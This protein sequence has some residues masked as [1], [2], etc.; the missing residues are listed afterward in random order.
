MR[1]QYSM[2]RSLWARYKKTIIVVGVTLMALVTVV[3]GGVSYAVYQ[4]AVYAKETFQSWDG[5]LEVPGGDK[6]VLP[7][8]GWVEGFV[9]SVG[10]LW[11]QQNIA[12][13][14]T[15]QLKN[16]LSCFDAIGGPSPLEMVTFVKSKVNDE[17]LTR[18]LNTLTQSLQDS[19]PLN[20]GPAAC[21][22]WML[23]G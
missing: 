1:N 20:R 2:K 17:R 13:Q 8:R 10:S 4:S 19:D 3:I 21:A 6:V 9:V 11:L 16:G 23:N 5:T 7:N 15:A 18:E 14:N 12:E 22:N